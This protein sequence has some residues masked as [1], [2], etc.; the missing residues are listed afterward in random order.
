[1]LNKKYVPKRQGSSLTGYFHTKQTVEYS[2]VTIPMG[3]SLQ[4][5]GIKNDFSGWTAAYDRGIVA[6]V[7]FHLPLRLWNDVNH[8]DTR[9][10]QH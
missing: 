8:C 6:A 4:N 1:M 9:A 10:M 7:K 5:P 3:F 2:I